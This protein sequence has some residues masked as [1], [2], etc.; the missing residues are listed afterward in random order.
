[1]AREGGL[2]QV[3]LNLRDVSTMRWRARIPECSAMAAVEGCVWR[4]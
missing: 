1:M 4:V 3:K 2:V